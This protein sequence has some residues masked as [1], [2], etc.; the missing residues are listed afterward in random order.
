M[1]LNENDSYLQQ[2]KLVVTSSEMN[3]SDDHLT[4]VCARAVGLVSLFFLPRNLT[5]LDPQSGIALLGAKLLVE[6]R[7]AELRNE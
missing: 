7:S 4:L 5:K 6:K 2:R 1:D 3:W